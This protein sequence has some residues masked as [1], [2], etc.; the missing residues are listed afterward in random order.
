MSTE[1]DVIVA[2]NWKMHKTIEEA[3]AFV[4][5]LLPLIQ[6][7][8]SKVYLAVPFTCIHPLAPL[9]GSSITLG[10][11]NIYA[12]EQGAF[13]GEISAKMVRDAGGRFALIGHSERRRL[14]HENDE[15]INRK[16]HC[17]YA[18]NLQPMLCVGETLEERKQGESAAVL[19]KQLIQGLKDI[20]SGQ[21]SSLIVAY[22]PVWAIGTKETATPQII[23]EA[24]AECRAALKELYGN[25][26]AEQIPIIYG[27]SVTAENGGVLIDEADI[28]GV[29][30][31]GASLSAKS[32]SQI[33]NY[34]SN[35]R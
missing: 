23:D 5:E 12:A 21:A 1:R 13:T 4:N 25:A 33:V 34:Q 15:L 10:S 35:T 17:A 32:F 6:Q 9:C 27:G 11:Q 16:I 30:V 28:D 31:G 14:F 18:E 26:I 2:G 20:S 19:K 3:L 22:E 8:S 7:A 24:H 29:L